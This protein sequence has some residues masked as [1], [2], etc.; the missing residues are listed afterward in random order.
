MAQRKA[1]TTYEDSA[2]K[3]LKQTRKIQKWSLIATILEN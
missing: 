3:T 2:L 1:W